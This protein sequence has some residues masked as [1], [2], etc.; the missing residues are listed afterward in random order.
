MEFQT[1]FQEMLQAT[2]SHDSDHPAGMR[3]EKAELR[4]ILERLSNQPVQ[5]S[6][7]AGAGH[8]ARR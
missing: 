3:A 6:A 5:P 4:C 7:P 1:A 2:T 8:P